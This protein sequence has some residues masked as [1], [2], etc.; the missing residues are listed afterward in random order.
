MTS[1]NSSARA[2]SGKP[3]R[4]ANDQF[5]SLNSQFRRAITSS[6][7]ILFLT[8]LLSLLPFHTATAADPP[9]RPN[10]LWIIADDL[11]AELGCY[12][13]PLMRTPNID[14]LASQGARFTRCFTTAPVCSPSRSAI[15]TGMYQTTIN[16]HD[17]RS[18]TALPPDVKPITDYFRQ[19]G[20]FTANLK[21]IAP[22]L[23]SH[24]KTD[25]NFKVEK[26]FDGDDFDELKS[27]QPFFAETQFFEPH[28][29]SW[30]PGK[31]LD[32][33]VDPAK[34][35]LPPYYPDDPVVRKDWADYLDIIDYLDTK[36]ATVL[37]RLE[38]EG[39]AGNTIIFFFGDNGRCHVRDKQWLYEGGLH[40]P[41]IIRWPGKLKPGSVRDDLVSAIDIS[42]TSLKIAGVA[43]PTNM[44]GRAFLDPGV[45]PRK[46]IFG[47]RDRCDETV[48]RIRSVRDDRYKYI[49]NFMPD[50]PYT[51]R[52]AY[53]ERAY[54]ALAVL[55][56]LHAEGKLTPAQEIFMAPTRPLEELYD[57]KT[58]PHETHNLAASADHQKILSELR[59]VLQ[60]WMTECDDRPDKHG[61]FRQ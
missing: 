17:H 53:K 49:R 11:G 29:G 3:C 61:E 2:L 21:K 51:Q 8:A 42:A 57:L 43:L 27:H 6:R 30:A 35:E 45:T 1:P 40:I 23:E 31:T 7:M 19:A 37:K 58:D 22:G 18:M 16:A 34:V 14:N 47:A 44:Q 59:D 10:I 5:L 13:T 25:F 54:P 38:V 41:L 55:K 15:M 52:N 46:Y 4:N 60:K 50:R 48:D 9:T 36:V 24:A 20:Y 39:L 26:P 28:R 33:R 32:Y 12:A 56:R